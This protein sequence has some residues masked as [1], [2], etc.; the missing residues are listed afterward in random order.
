M[1]SGRRQPGRPGSQEPISTR[2]M[3]TTSND[4]SGYRIVRHLGVVRGVTVRS[5]NLF[6]MIGGS[7]Q[8]LFG[9][10]V[11]LFTALSERTRQEAYDLMEAH[12]AE[13]GGNAIIAMR[14]DANE[15]A[16]GITEVLAYGTAV[17]I[18]PVG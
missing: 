2:I 12:A 4:F 1:E 10:N 6:G 7:I 16:A 17:V 3:V 15:V 11:S 14:Y 13:I 9:G 8:S 18:E 5:R